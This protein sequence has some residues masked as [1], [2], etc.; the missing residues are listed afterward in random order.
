VQ[1]EVDPGDLSSASKVT[2]LTVNLTGDKVDPKSK[3]GQFIP[4]APSFPPYLAD[5]T[6]AEVTG[7]KKLMFA[8]VGPPA[9]P[10]NPPK[11]TIDGK[12]FD[13]EV[14]AVVLLNTVEEWTVMNTTPNISHPFHIHINPFQV[15]EVFEPNA[16]INDPATGQPVNKYVFDRSDLKVAGQCL[17]DRFNS[18][19]WKPCDAPEVVTNRIWWDVFPIPSGRKVNTKAK[20]TT[21]PATG[22]PTV[23]LDS[24]GKVVYEQVTVPGYF[25]MRSRF[26]DYAGY[27]VLHCH[28]LAHEDRGMM[29]IVEVAP[30]RTPY[31][32]H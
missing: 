4:Q 2:F 25:K 23:V 18:D 28:I 26:V 32:H 7:K 13:G 17:L 24:N 1:N 31:S 8:T 12:S 22:K 27:Y 15:V 29:T 3:Q 19:T 6:S 10:P 14:G 20:L 30:S 5:I 16:T 11:H 9:G 21:D